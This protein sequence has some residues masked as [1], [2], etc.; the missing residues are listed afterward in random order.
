MARLEDQ[1]EWCQERCSGAWTEVNARSI[2]STFGGDGTEMREYDARS[3]V[4]K[5]MEITVVSLLVLFGDGRLFYESPAEG[6]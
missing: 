1:W 4:G 2:F 5:M 3:A 6:G